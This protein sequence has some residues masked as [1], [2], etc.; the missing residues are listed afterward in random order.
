VILN[1]Q[2]EYPALSEYIIDELIANTVN[3]RVFPVVD[4]QQLDVIRG[5][6]DFQTSG[7]VD[8]N[9]AQELGR[10]AG[11][12]II[13]S[14]AVSKIGDLYRLRVRALNVQ[15]AQIGGQFNRNI[16][17]GPIIAARV[18]S[19]ATGY[20]GSG[21]QPAT[22]TATPPAT[23]PA[24]AGAPQKAQV[25][26][27]PARPGTVYTGNGHSY[28][29]VNKTMSWTDARRSCEE[30]GGYLATITSSGE[31]TFI[32]NLLA[33]EGDK[34]VYWLGG[35][36]GNDRKFQWVTG[37]RFEYAN[38]MPGQPDNA[39]RVEDKLEI[40][41]V[42]APYTSNSRPGDWNDTPTNTNILKKDRYDYYSQDF[43]F[44]CEFDP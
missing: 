6:L 25:P 20:G 12:Q 42:A 28:E 8:D 41:R 44:I 19:Q 11:A 9:T 31:Q 21:G 17:D 37:E 40:T 3:D 30:R 27:T 32:E 38:W 23:V 14:G 2:S 5:E 13:V 35:Y 7:E 29:A 43:G 22:K 16:P 34:S 4:R 10:M 33:R 26:A 15:T 39:G 18:R 24:V 1:I 36:C